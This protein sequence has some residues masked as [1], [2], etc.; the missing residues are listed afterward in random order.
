MKDFVLLFSAETDIQKAF[1]RY[2]D[3]TEG[4]VM[5]LRQDLLKIQEKLKV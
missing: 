5:D 3:Q 4:L 1:E 2:N